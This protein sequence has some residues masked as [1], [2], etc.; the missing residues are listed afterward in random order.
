MHALT[1]HLPT[2]GAYNMHTAHGKVLY[3]IRIGLHAHLM[4]REKR[5]E[6]YH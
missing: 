2:E 6:Y 5:E 1:M 4:L 3:E